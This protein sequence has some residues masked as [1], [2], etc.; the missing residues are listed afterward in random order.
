M[1]SAALIIG[2]LCLDVTAQISVQGEALAA[3]PDNASIVADGAVALAPGGTAWLFANALA[4][5]TG[6]V[7]LIAAAVGTD[8]AGD[9]LAASVAEQDF[10]ADGLLR[11][12]GTPTDIVSITSFPGT[13][14]LLARPAEK[15]MRKVHAWEWERIADMVDAHDVRFAWVSGYIFEDYDT[16]TL[17]HTRTLFGQLRE[18]AIPIVLDLVPHDF[19]NKIGRL[20]DLETDVGPIDVLVGEFRTVVG[21]GFGQAVPPGDDVRPAMLGCARTIARTRAGAVI[22]HRVSTS[23]YALAVAGPQ[24]GERVMNQEIPASGPRGMGDVL[25]VQGLQVLCL[26]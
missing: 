17:E 15:V 11:A 5:L 16:A 24:L 1:R 26:A 13:G 9:L 8:L 21:L 23:H 3:L 6:L 25:A 2:E 7:P 12:G 19:V 20:R 10:P 14:R 4:S 18:R 22:Q